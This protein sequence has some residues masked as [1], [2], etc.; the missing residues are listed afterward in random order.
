MISELSNVLIQQCS[1]GN[2]MTQLPTALALGAWLEKHSDQVG[3]ALDSLLTT[4]GV[5][6]AAPPPKKDSFGRDIFIDFRDQWECRVGVAKALEQLSKCAD[7]AKAMRFLKFVI[8]EALADPS[9]EVRSAMMAAAQA[10]IGCHGDSL[11]GELMA[12]SEESLKSIPD[13]AEADT[14]RQAIIVLMGVLAKHLDKDNPKV[15]V[16]MHV[17]AMIHA[18]TC[19]T[20]HDACCFVCRSRLWCICC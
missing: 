16:H 4:Y 13:S 18:C 10:T 9:P 14:V 2:L 1:S 19:V 20:C 3:Q 8:P 11:A 6:R 7:S 17:H 12:H 5:K 15:H